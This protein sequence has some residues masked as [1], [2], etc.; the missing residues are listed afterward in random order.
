MLVDGLV[1]ALAYYLAF[2]LRFPNRMPARYDEL[3]ENTIPW[4]VPLTVAVLA[5]FGVYQRIW[6]FV[7]Q[8]EY[9]GVVKAMLTATV[10]VVAVI[11][12][13]HPVV[14]PP[15][16]AVGLPASVVALY[17]LLA[18]ALLLGSRF[19]IHLVVEGRARGP[20][21][22][23]GARDVLIVG[24][25]EGKAG[26]ARALPQPAAGDATGRL[27]GRRSPQAGDQG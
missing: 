27:R 19:A 2:R 14:M 6:T 8:R 9:E 21:T 4:V 24:G 5:A 1:V 7:G 15:N 3:L 22:A 18:L 10:L 12:F 11:A 25:G 16:G 17:F 13:A 23:M 20:R 26:G